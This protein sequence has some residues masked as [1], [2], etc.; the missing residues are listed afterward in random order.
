[1]TE[2]TIHSAL[3]ADLMRDALQAAGYRV[4]TVTAPGGELVLRS[5]TAGLGF[6][7]SFP[8]APAPAPGAGSP[9]F[10]DAVFRAVLRVEGTL[11]L[12]LVNRWNVTR[13]FARLGLNGDL[14][15]LDLDLLAAGGITP[16]ALSTQ[17]GL[18]DRLTQMLLAYLREELPRLEAAAIEVGP[19]LATADGA[20]V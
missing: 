17:I 1:M 2:T 11:P 19:P 3:T 7:V 14:L 13:R 12:D 10:A 8:P 9:G 15:A 20:A 18:W 5:A 16:A 4:E 6:T